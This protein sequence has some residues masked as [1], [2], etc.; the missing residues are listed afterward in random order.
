M[1]QLLQKLDDLRVLTLSAAAAKATASNSPPPPAAGAAV[2]AGHASSPPAAPAA[3]ASTDTGDASAAAAGGAELPDSTVRITLEL[4]HLQVAEPADAVFK[5]LTAAG[6]AQLQ[7]LLQ[8]QCHAASRPATAA[9]GQTGWSA[10][11]LSGAN[12]T[13]GS[14]AGSTPDTARAAPSHGGL[15]SSGA[16]SSS[17]SSAFVGLHRAV[18][19]LPVRYHLEVCGPDGT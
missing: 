12:S 11:S 17:G 4:D 14:N 13:S 5:A 6:S 16:A 8:Q 19:L 18:P 7:H 9:E 3:A 1:L 10:A 2:I 15:S